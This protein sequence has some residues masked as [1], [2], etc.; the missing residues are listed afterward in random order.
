LSNLFGVSYDN[1]VEGPMH[2]SYLRLQPDAQTKQ[3]HPVL[4][5][6]ENAYRI[7]NT[8]HSVKVT[9]APGTNFPSP[10]TLI[11]TYPDLPMED[12]YPRIPQTNIRELYLNE[13]GKGRV[14]YIPGDI[15]R[16]Y[17]QLMVSDYGTLL[18]NTIRWALNEES[19][20]TVA[21]PGVIDVAVW[22]QKNS[23]TVHLVNLTNPMMMRGTFREFFPV[24]ADINIQIPQNKKVGS[25]RLLMAGSSP[26]FENTKGNV[27]LHVPKISDH[28]IVAIDFV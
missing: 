2:N 10:V 22:Q 14:A 20:V 15:D 3:F 19:I 11:P 7:I 5:S 27:K 21:G 6:L 8:I 23:M 18:R 4:K 26:S 17:W 12:V 13:T 28:E 9:P 16:T 1:A 25:V 24:A